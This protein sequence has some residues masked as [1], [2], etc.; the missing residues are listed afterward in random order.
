VFNLAG[1]D[2]DSKEPAVG[3]LGHNSK[4]RI[5]SARLH[6]IL[7]S[8]PQMVWTN[9]PD[10]HQSYYNKQWYA[11]TG[12]EPCAPE[13]VRRS[14]LLHPEDREQAL[15]AWHYSLATGEPYQAEYRLRHYSGEYRWVLSRGDPERNAAGNIVRWYGSTTDIDQQKIE[16]HEA[17]VREA[18]SQQASTSEARLRS[19]LDS[20]PQMVWTNEANGQQSFYN[21]QWYAYTGL[22]QGPAHEVSRRHLIHPDD[23]ARAMAAWEHSI[24]SGEAYQAEYRLRHHSGEYRWVLSR[25]VPERNPSGEVLGWYG[26]TTEIDE[27]VKAREKLAS[28]ADDLEKARLMAEEAGAAKAAFLANMSHEIRTPLNSIIGFTDLLLDDSALTPGQK[29]QLSL[30]QNSGNALLTVVNDVLDLSKIE[31]GKVELIEE[32]FALESFIDNTISIVAGNAE[33]KGLELRVRTDPTL[34]RCHRGDEGRLRQVLLNFLNNAV[35]FTSVGFVSVEV[36]RLAGGERA[37][38]LRFEI[39]DT[40]TG[41]PQEKLGRLFQQFSQ[42]DASVSREFGG[43]GLGLSIA[44]NLVERMGG[45]VGVSSEDGVGSTFWFEL[46][47]PIAEETAGPVQVS[48]LPA[49]L[50]RAKILLVED[51]PMNQE[52]ACAILH[53]AGH[54]VDVAGDGAE[55]VRAVQEKA[56]DLVLMDIQMPKVDGLTA[57]RMIRALDGPAREVPIIAMTANVLPEQVKEFRKTG[58]TGHVAKPIRQAEL[59]RAIARALGDDRAAADE[60][61]ADERKLFDRDI[62]TKIATLLPQDR[63]TAHLASFETQLRSAFTDASERKTLASTCHK[64]VS[65]AGMLGF[66][67]LSDQCRAL[68]EACLAEVDINYELAAARQTALA[69]LDLIESLTAQ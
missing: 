49:E 62:Y 50:R 68:E 63:L 38:R 56:Y 10:G 61:G 34:H 35:K 26:T 20:I 41:V 60:E 18:R 22:A 27:Q 57:T 1:E 24:A 31:A 44:K 3:G 29:R 28:L 58:M 69:V 39:S 30:I 2:P 4:A 9:E 13:D 32:A 42:A 5:S 67:L 14:K 23:L 45:T 47:L 65:Q 48:A 16:Q 51:L 25:G 53:R 17:L 54:D 8:I 21:R 11:F 46:E 37:E 52:L 6:R 36:R 7:D 64:L 59:H 40:G 55:A 12:L 66:M 15:A 33:A 43:T 19:I